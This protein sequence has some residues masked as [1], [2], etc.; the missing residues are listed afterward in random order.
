MLNAYIIGALTGS[1]LTFVLIGQLLTSRRPTGPSMKHF[2]PAMLCAL[3]IMLAGCS[4][5]TS[6]TNATPTARPSTTK[7]PIVLTV[8]AITA[9]P[10]TPAS[11]SS[12]WTTYHHD[13]SRTGYLASAPDP[14][15]L[16]S[17]WNVQLDGAVYGEPLVIGGHV[18][19]ATEGDSLYSLDAQTGHILWRTNVGSPVPLRDLPCGNID[20]LG[21]TGTPVYD[22]ATGLVFA[23]A[24]VSGFAHILVG[25]DAGTGQVRVRRSA[26]VAGMDTRV[27]QQRAALAL[28]QGMVYIAY[29]GL[30]G[31]CGDYIGRVVASRTDG[32]GPL[33]SYQVPTPREGGIW[34]ASGPAVDAGS[35]IYV[36]VGNGAITQGN[37]DHSD[38]VLRL[39]PALQLEDG[40]APQQWQQD[41]AGDADLGSTGP[42]LLPNG[43]IYV[44]GKSGLGY[45]LHA[46]SL[47]GVGGQA[48][49]LSI[50]ASF[51]GA[52]AIGS[53]VFVPCT[54]GLREVLV[55]PGDHL[56]VGWHAPGQATGSPVAGGTTVYSLD[57]GGTL[58]AINSQ[59]GAVISTVGIGQTS[60]FATPTLYNGSVFVGTLSGV[61]AVGAS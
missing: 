3:L 5:L 2:Q 61:A 10:T 20:P 55:G 34:A 48:Q 33:L 28:S 60:R 44:N 53:R 8:P 49:V 50:C 57:P 21:I 36:A 27:H 12:D 15:R 14:Q 43:L 42:I 40:F 32:Q 11:N 56:A 29:G 37:W 13:N 46:D 51:G 7:P 4:N 1:A 9:T 41:N 59:N 54:D 35:N 45:L 22:P 23:V 39:S 16:T 19:V 24:E 38:S 52:A 25:V 58:Y 17:L 30:D 6:T 26:D 18:I 31:D 47:G